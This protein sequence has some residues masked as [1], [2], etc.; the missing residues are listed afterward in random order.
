[1]KNSVFFQQKRTRINLILL[2]VFLFLIIL[3]SSRANAQ[4]DVT[5]LFGVVGIHN[6]DNSF[7][8]GGIE[9]GSINLEN[10]WGFGLSVS[11]IA[12]NDFDLTFAHMNFLCRVKDDFLI[13][14]SLGTESKS[15]DDIMPSI[16]FGGMYF[17][18]NSK[19]Y[20][21][22]RGY[23]SFI[24]VPHDEVSFSNISGHLGLRF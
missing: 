5:G 2:L 12:G 1:M 23:L 6:F 15:R 24:T 4:R 7:Q 9:I 16:G 20:I 13:P 3:F 18:K 21:S 17:I 14:L 8:G 19:F 11:R 22:L 10:T